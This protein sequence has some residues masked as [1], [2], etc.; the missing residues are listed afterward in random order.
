VWGRLSARQARELARVLE[1]LS[2]NAEALARQI[3]ASPA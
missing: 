3:A 1:T 2:V